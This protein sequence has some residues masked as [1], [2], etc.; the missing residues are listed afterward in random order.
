MEANIET[1]G[2]RWLI[3]AQ[4]QME[5]L[6]GRLPLTRDFTFTDPFGLNLVK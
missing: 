3:R 4:R 6:R 2:L 1:M 5:E